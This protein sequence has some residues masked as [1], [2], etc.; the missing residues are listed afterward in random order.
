[1]A[2]IKPFKGWRYNPSHFSDISELTS[3][4]FDVVTQEQRDEL[5][6]NSLNS[7]HLSVPLGPQPYRHALQ[8]LEEWEQKEVLLQD[9]VPALY[10][11]YQYFKL[12]G[13]KKEFVRKGFVCM[14]KAER[15]Q[16]LLHENTIPGAVNDR[17]R[18]L[19]ETGLNVSPTHGLYADPEHRLEQLMDDAIQ[20]PIYDTEN[21]FGV[22]EVVSAITDSAIIEQFTSLMAAQQVILADGHHRFESSLTLK[23]N[24]EAG[25]APA[26]SVANSSSESAYA[27]HLMYMTN[28]ESP[29]LKIL[30]THRLVTSWGNLTQNDLLERLG[31]Y[32][33]IYPVADPLELDEMI[34]GKAY[35]FGLITQGFSCKLRL[36]PNLT[37]NIQWNFPDIIK[38]LDLTV[39]HYFVLEKSFGIA[40]KNQRSDEKLAFERNFTRC[41][42]QVQEH[43]AAAALIVNGVSMEEVKKVCYSGFT[44]PQKSTYFYPKITCGYVM[45]N[46]TDCF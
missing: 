2:E 35:A 42:R 31:K 22:R 13:I 23:E 12:K 21:Y 33:Y 4:L 11:Y 38:R 18:L 26:P 27:Y 30:P 44:L 39:L 40:G 32:F 9:E 8:V 24:V 25:K 34:A 3:P 45:A 10:V 7:I 43:K 6:K 17:I 36:K 28:T 15:D 1:M 41:V 37:E 5:Y 19:E 14:I 46:I 16:I 29:D 20:R